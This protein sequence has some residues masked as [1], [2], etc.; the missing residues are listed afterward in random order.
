MVIPFLFCAVLLQGPTAPQSSTPATLPPLL[1]KDTIQDFPRS[2]LQIKPAEQGGMERGNV[3][4]AFL[5]AGEGGDFDLGMAQQELDQLEG[6]IT[7]GTE[8][9]DSNHVRKNPK[10]EARNSK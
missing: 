2:Q 9:C 10:P 8:D 7:G 3:R 4:I 6:C 1:L 5:A